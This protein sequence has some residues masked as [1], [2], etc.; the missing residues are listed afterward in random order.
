MPVNKNA[1]QPVKRN[2]ITRKAPGTRLG[3]LQDWRGIDNNSR[4]TSGR[5][6]QSVRD[7]R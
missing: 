6:G 7:G 2:Q 3:T 1:T 5:H 4:K